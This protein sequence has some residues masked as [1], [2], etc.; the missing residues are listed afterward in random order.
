MVAGELGRFRKGQQLV[1]FI[2][3]RL[4]DLSGSPFQRA[5]AAVVAKDLPEL[6]G[7]GAE[8]YDALLNGTLFR[9]QKTHPPKSLSLRGVLLVRAGDFMRG[10]RQSQGRRSTIERIPGPICR[11]S[12]RA[13]RKSALISCGLIPQLS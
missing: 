7:L 10:E 11:K 3:E 2:A 4:L 8:L 1:V 5:S 6:L 12:D 9:D 13:C